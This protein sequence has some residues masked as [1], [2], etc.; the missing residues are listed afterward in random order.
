M[1]NATVTPSVACRNWPHNVLRRQQHHGVTKNCAV[2]RR[3]K[4]LLAIKQ[5]TH[6]QHAQQRVDDTRNN[7]GDASRAFVRCDIVCP[8]DKHRLG[9]L[10]Q[11]AVKLF[12][13][14]AALVLVG[15]PL[16]A[17]AGEIIQ[18]MPRVADGD[19]LQ[20]RRQSKPLC[21]KAALPI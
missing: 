11:L 19:T 5:T 1:V 17:M 18:G 14:L 20:V 10:P 15:Q 13:A 3:T 7:A 21:S 16:P 8:H 2:H 6:I 12:E 4:C 9:C